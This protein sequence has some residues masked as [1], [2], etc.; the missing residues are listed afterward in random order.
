M[1]LAVVAMES[2]AFDEWLAL[3]QAQASPVSDDAAGG[4]G[5]FVD[6]G[7]DKCH[8]IRGTEADGTG[9]PDLTHV[10]SR[11]TI[12]SLLLPNDRASLARWISEPHAI[13][14]GVQ[15]PAAELSVDRLDA[16]VTYLDG[17]E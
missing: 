12:A 9:G 16:L 5:V 13:K 17:L 2:A 10:G 11:S 8:T 7:C 15:M 1:H 3:Q 4:F 14:E 6:A